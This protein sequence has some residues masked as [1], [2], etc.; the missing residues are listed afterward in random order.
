MWVSYVEIYNDYVYDLLERPPSGQ[1]RRTAL[2]LGLDKKGNT[3]VK[4]E[5]RLLSKLPGAS[6]PPLS[7]SHCLLVPR[8]CKVNIAKSETKTPTLPARDSTDY[9]NTDK[10]LTLSA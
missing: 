6:P 8:P 7:P 2:P 9:Q 1:R 4:G 3:F 10:T 5:S